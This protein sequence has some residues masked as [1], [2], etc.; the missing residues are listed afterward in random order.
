[1][2]GRAYLAALL[3]PLTYSTVY[4]MTNVPDALTLDVRHEADAIEVQ[5]IGDSPRAQEV[6]YILEVTGSSTS[7]HRGKTKLTANA[8]TVL[9]TVRAS[10]G[11]NWCVRLLAE[12]EGRAPY[13]I[14]KGRC[15]EGK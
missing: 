11:E 8:R 10:A 4:A 3:I 1:M 14:Q 5:L 2:N 9:A 7:H 13:E 6:S 12:E 15:M